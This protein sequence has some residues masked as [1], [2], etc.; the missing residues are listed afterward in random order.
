LADIPD[1]DRGELQSDTLEFERVRRRPPG[2]R[3]GILVLIV[4]LILAGASYGGW[5]AMGGQLF[6][7]GADDVPVI[8][9][10]AGPLKVR[11]DK[12]GGIEIK[13][14]D[15]EVYKRIGGDQPERSAETLLPRP[16]NPLPSPASTGTRP[17]KPAAKDTAAGGPAKS[18]EKLIAA[19]E[20]EDVQKP[21]T[22]AAKP[23]QKSQDAGAEAAAKP[24]PA[25]PSPAEPSPAKPSPEKVIAVQKPPPAPPP[26]E[27]KTPEAAPEASLASKPE[28]QL[29]AATLPGSGYS[30]QLAAVRDEKAAGG[31]WR[32]LRGRHAELL[33]KLS[34]SVVR[35]D[36]GARGIFYRLRAG[37]LPDKDTAR[38]LCRALAKKKVGCLVVAPGG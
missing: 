10:A 15:I 9:A 6:G 8:Q 21:E 34:L 3:R 20:A 18:A 36:L 26:P 23:A 11:P 27:V 2:R 28:I 4:L 25:E 14:R 22:S 35:A 24:S 17:A 19:S 12:P 30:V 1:F 13:N 16:E 29:P 31:E 32:R 38:Q 37:T 5:L 33:G 7:T